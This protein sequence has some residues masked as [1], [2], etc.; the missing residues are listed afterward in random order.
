M[1]AKFKMQNLQYKIQSSKSKNFTFYILHSTFRRPRGFTLIEVLVAGAILSLVLAALYGAFSRTLTSKHVAEERAARSRVARIVLLRISEDLQASFPFAPDNARFISR[2]FRESAFPED[3]LSFIALAYR[4]LTD[5][6]AEGDLCEIGYA[7]V[8]DPEVPAYR[9]LVRRVQPDLVADRD[10]TRDIYPLLVQ[11]RGLRF[12]F[13]D[14][15]TWR[16][17]WGRENTQNTLPRAVEVVLYL[18]DPSTG[19]LQAGDPAEKVVAF[20]TV[21]DLPLAKRQ[22]AGAS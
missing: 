5:A 2:T 21:I 12:R 18:A 15:R 14:G 6:N 9:Q 10:A 22:S 20:S 3:A 17:E 16:E 11:V 1:N 8:P 4:P 13:F 7:L 19:S